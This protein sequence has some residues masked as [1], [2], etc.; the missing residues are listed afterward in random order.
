M[1][2]RPGDVSTAAKESILTPLSKE[3]DSSYLPH[4][5]EMLELLPMLVAWLGYFQLGLP[6]SCCCLKSDFKQL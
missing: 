3:T 6:K 4:D 5:L 1:F 2:D